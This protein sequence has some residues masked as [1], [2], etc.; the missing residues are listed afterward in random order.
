MRFSEGDIRHPA[1]SQRTGKRD[2]E[3]TRII[4]SVGSEMVLDHAQV[5]HNG[6]M[7]G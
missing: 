4:S 7:L 3:A 5:R 1:L 2:L 6:E